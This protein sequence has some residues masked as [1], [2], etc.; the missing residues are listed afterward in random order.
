VT[1]ILDLIGVLA[2]FV[3]LIALRPNPRGSRRRW[4]HRG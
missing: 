2:L 4:W 3:F 1:H